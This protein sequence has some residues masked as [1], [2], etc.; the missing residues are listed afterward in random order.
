MAH[1]RFSEMGT[2]AFRARSLSIASS[3]S[4]RA[5]SPGDQ[6]PRQVC[7]SRP[8]PARLAA[9]LRDEQV[10]SAKPHAPCRH[11]GF[12]EGVC[13]G[14]NAPARPSHR[15][16]EQRRRYALPPPMA[17]EGHR[18]AGRAG[19]QQSPKK[20]GWPRSNSTWVTSPF[21]TVTCATRIVEAVMQRRV[22]STF[23]DADPTVQR[24][25]EWG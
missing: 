2:R 19:F 4:A 23:S 16:R 21:V 25:V 18:G 24:I 7:E 13:D 11:S 14:L 10:A 3:P 17:G 6:L 1:G 12:L 22:A 20:W 15:A 8:V 5:A 9:G